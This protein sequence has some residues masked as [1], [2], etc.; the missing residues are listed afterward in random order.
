MF[1]LLISPKFVGFKNGL[2]RSRSK[3]KIKVLTLTGT[4]ILF[5]LA[6]FFLSCRVLIYFSSQEI[7][8]DILAR[9]LLAMA[10]LIFFS[11]LIFSHIITA[12]SNL[13]IS[14]D[15]EL[16]HSSPARLTEIFL[17]RSFYTVID[18]SWMLL[19]FGLPVMMAYGFVYHAGLDYYLS[20]IHVSFPLIIIAASLGIM[21][22][23]V[24]V[25]F[26]PAQRA[27]DIIMFLSLILIV[28]LYLLFRFLRPERLVNP[29][30]FI[31]VAQ[32][33]GAL[34]APDSPYLPSHWATEIL[35]ARLIKYTGG[36]VLNHL[37]LWSTA[38]ALVVI[39][40]WMAGLIY[41]DGFSRAQEAKRRSRTGRKILER[42]VSVITRPLGPDMTSLIAKD[43]R[44]FFRDNSQWSQ[45]LLLGA[46]VVVY[47]YNF[48]VLPLERSPIRS[49][50]LQNALSFLNIGLA[51][52][53]ISAL[54]VRF[55]F[56][57]VSSEG[58]AFWIILSSPL[59][60]RRFLWSKFLA[61]LLPMLVLA[62]MLIIYTNYLLK[63][64]PFMMAL[65]SV[66]IFFLVFGIVALGVGLGAVYPNFRH[67]NIAQVATG[68]GGLIYMIISSVFIALVIMLEAGPVYTILS[69][70]FRGEEITHLQWIWI[71]GSFIM[72]IFLN[73]FAVQRPMAAGLKAINGY[74]G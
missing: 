5:W 66:T 11:L 17:S 57:A 39:D 23:M 67:E 52:F 16:C 69:T 72:V 8:G 41:F 9:H 26:F 3:I 12:L 62:E 70:H 25:R 71:V 19:V 22:I 73:I 30:T 24:L 38:F 63:V 43:V 21:L 27:R 34:K 40:I 18:S 14:Q 45:L 2:K 58:Q 51:G 15:L 7:I 36:H 35:W 59:S 4:G 54:S 1:R 13:Y 32:Y 56:P 64:T 53:V 42:I 65:S 60:P 6:L 31:S 28:I 33:L 37:L 74:E 48:S 50:Y 10:L 29:E 61:Y 55:I 49:I 44:T 47:L 20:L 68:F 46:L